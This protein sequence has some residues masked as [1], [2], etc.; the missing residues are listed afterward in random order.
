LY[1]LESHEYFA[2]RDVKF[3]KHKFP[4][5]VSVD[6]TLYTS[7]INFDIEYVDNDIG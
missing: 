1:D 5:V 6:K 7:Y 3:Y 2:S 4:Y